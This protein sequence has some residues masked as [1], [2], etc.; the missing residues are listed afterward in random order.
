MFLSFQKDPSQQNLQNRATR[1]QAVTNQRTEGSKPSQFL[2]KDHPKYPR[3]TSSRQNLTS[4]KDA[5][6][7]SSKKGINLSR[8]DL[9]ELIF[10]D[11]KVFAA[12]IGMK[13]SNLNSPK[14]GK[15]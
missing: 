8:R 3:A 6:L 5:E 4:S 14:D 2:S 10:V 11:K 13:I 12:D 9:K 7:F 15:A 1:N